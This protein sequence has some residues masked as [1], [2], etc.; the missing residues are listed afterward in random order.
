MQRIVITGASDG[1]GAASARQL[2]AR[3]FEVVIVGRS[4]EKTKALAQQL[5][6]P[7]HLADFAKF[8]EVRRLIQELSQYD[9]IDVLANNAG[10]IRPERR[11]T[12]DGFEETL[13]INHLSPFLLTM[14]LMDKLTASRAR[15]IQTASRAANH[16]GGHFDLDDLGGERRYSPWSAYG[17]SK[18]CNVLFTRELYRRYGSEGIAAVAFHPGVVRSNFGSDA[19]PALRLLYHTPLKYTFTISTE[20]SARR[21]SALVE[22]TPGEDWQSGE[23]YA[24]KKPMHVRFKDGNGSIALALWEMSCAMVGRG[25]SDNA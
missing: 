23:V 20:A 3:G 10:T 22:G 14:G 16:F 4:P 13:Q 8:A 1:I 21:L 19:M 9:R 17:R 11:M 18:L 5:G 15:I 6:A 12:E 25:Q 2:R 24:G 7:C